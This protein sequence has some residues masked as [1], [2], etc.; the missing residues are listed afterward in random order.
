MLTIFSATATASCSSESVSSKGSADTAEAVFTD[1]G[2]GAR[3]G[4]GGRGFGAAEGAPL[5]FEAVAAI[6]W[7]RGQ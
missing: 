7:H 5:G 4:V 6:R 1:G 2:G 3:R